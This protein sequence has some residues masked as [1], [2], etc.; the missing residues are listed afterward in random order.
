[1]TEQTKMQGSAPAAR[2]NKSLI[3]LVTKSCGDE[4]RYP[5]CIVGDVTWQRCRNREDA[6]IAALSPAEQSEA[7]PPV[8]SSPAPIPGSVDLEEMESIKALALTGSMDASLSANTL[9]LILGD[10]FEVARRSLSNR[11]G[12]TE[13]E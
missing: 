6:A 3:R 4:C 1:M 7:E 11:I 2:E 13:S 10:I 9:R 5:L 8:L 12:Q